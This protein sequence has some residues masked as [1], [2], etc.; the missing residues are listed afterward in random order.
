M[1]ADGMARHSGDLVL[2]GAGGFARGAA[3]AVHALDRNGADRRLL[4]Y[5]DGDPRRGT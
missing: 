3:Q 4:R 1:S 2:V 5:V